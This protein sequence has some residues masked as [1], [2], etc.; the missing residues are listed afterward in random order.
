VDE[1]LKESRLTV[2]TAAADEAAR[3]VRRRGDH[4]E[5]ILPG[6]ED[7]AERR[8]A[9]E[10]AR[11]HRE[12]L[13][14][15]LDSI[16]DAV[17]ATDAEGVLTCLNPAAESLTGWG[18]AEAAGQPL[19]AVF[20]LVH[21]TTRQPVPTPLKRVLGQGVGA[22]LAK[23]TLLVARDGTER[24]IAGS[25]APIHDGAG[26]LLGVVLIFRDVGAERQAEQEREAL[27]AR[28][29][30]ARAEVEA[31]EVRK[32]QFLAALGH[33]LRSPLESLHCALH[34]LGLQGHDAAVREPTCA[35]AARQLS[36][37]RRIVDDL[38]DLSRIGQG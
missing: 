30:A 28:A 5:A 9:A 23:Q 25:A 24:P 16:G 31:A 7:A 18:Q 6:F 27:L 34:V 3:R 11:P 1:M 38:L 36:Q 2:P 21:E 15:T 12:W 10:A 32:D 22:G 13:Q 20:F 37:L 33:E 14:V 29:Q 35:L 26:N 8:Q 19:E 4:T 17:I